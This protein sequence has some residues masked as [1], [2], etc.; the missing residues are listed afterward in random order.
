MAE[1]RRHNCKKYIYKLIM[2]KHLQKNL[3][4]FCMRIKEGT[5]NT[6]V[7][8]KIVWIQK[9]QWIE[10]TE[11]KYKRKKNKTEEEETK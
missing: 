2:I 9:R 8:S 4:L 11:D 5:I 1:A 6:N 10:Q 7:I 3:N